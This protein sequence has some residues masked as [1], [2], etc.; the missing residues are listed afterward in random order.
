MAYSYNLS[1]SFITPQGA[2]Q[3]D[4]YITTYIKNHKTYRI[5][6]IKSKHFA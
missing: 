5:K 3:I 6:M 4:I 2:A 1:S